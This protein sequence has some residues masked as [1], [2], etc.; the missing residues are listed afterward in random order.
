MMNDLETI[1]IFSECFPK[2]AQVICLQA[3]A[4]PLREWVGNSGASQSHPGQC[5]VF[6]VIGVMIVQNINHSASPT[7][8]P[9]RAGKG[10]EL[11]QKDA[12]SQEQFQIYRSCLK[13]CRGPQSRP[14]RCKPGLRPAKGG[15]GQKWG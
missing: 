1:R 3:D 15:V 13:R 14:H 10:W 5:T 6:G 11:L 9:Y 12:T 7:L 8:H 4:E 2:S